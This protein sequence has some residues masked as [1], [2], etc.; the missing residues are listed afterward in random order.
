MAIN[1]NEHTVS[2]SVSDEHVRVIRYLLTYELSQS[3]MFILA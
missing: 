1:A 3:N 2:G